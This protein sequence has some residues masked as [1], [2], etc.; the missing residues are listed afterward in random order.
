MRKLLLALMF[1]LLAINVYAGTIKNKD[2]H[3]SLFNTELGAEKDEVIIGDENSPNDFKPK[4][5]LTKW[6][7]EESLSIRYYGLTNASLVKTNDKI[8]LGNSDKDFYVLPYDTETLKF[9]LIFKTKPTSN[10]FEFKL[11]GWQNF[12]FCYQPELTAAEIAEGCSRPADVVG[13]YAVYHKTKANNQYKTGKFCHIY[14]PRFIDANNNFTW[15]E[16]NIKN[17]TY[18]VTIPQDFLET[19]AYPVKANDTVGLTTVGASEIGT[20]NANYSSKNTL[21]VNGTFTTMSIYLDDDDATY[22]VGIYDHDAVNDLPENLL[23]IS[24]TIDDPVGANWVETN[25]T[26]TAVSAGTIWLSLV[27]S[28]GSFTV[29]YD[30]NAAYRHASFVEASLTLSNPF[31]DSPAGTGTRRF[32]VYGTY[33][34][35][36]GGSSTPFFFIIS[37]D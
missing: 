29:H 36:A 6:N 17:G 2:N 10:V 5:K 8:T 32:S 11:E 14:R 34:E 13:S 3:N 16:L 23:V 28:T 31:T 37:G 12:D 30:S 18:T 25:I 7:K 22:K 4:I 19:A 9:G 15:G 33:T 24:D 20:L 21:S 1:C 35:T 26:D 27:M